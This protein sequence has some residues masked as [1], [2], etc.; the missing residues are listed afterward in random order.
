MDQDQIELYAQKSDIDNN[1]SDPTVIAKYRLA[2]DIAQDALTKVVARVVDGVRVSELCAYGDEII[3][4]YTSKVYNKNSVEKGIAFPTMISVNDCV[5]YYSPTGD[6]GDDVVL[7]NGDVVKI[8]LGAHIDGYIATNGHT[9]VLNSNPSMPVEGLAAD[10]VCAAYFAAE[11]ALRLMKTGNSNVQVQEAIAEAAALFNCSPVTGTA[12]TEI[13]RYVI[14]T[15]KLILNVPDEE[16]RPV[17][18]FVFVANEAYTLNILISSGDG[19]CREGAS[20]P[21]I[22]ARNVHQNYNLKLK[23]ARAAFNEIGTKFGVFPF[24]TRALEDKRHRLG[25]S[26][27]ASHNLLMPYPVYYTRASD[28]VAQ[29]KMTVLITA[30][31]TTRITPPLPLPFVHSAYTIPEDSNIA[32]IMASESVKVVKGGKALAGIGA[33]EIAAPAAGMEVDM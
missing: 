26:E 17:Q 18:D 7:H 9:V 14:S 32:K 6:A 33:T 11:A 21:T 2:A 5:E 13:K 10:V 24:T 4:S 31:G 28:R 25:V 19:T 12:S 16:N 1:L 27:L 30:N 15:E 29:F 3:L 20:R 23:S 8:E 22:Y